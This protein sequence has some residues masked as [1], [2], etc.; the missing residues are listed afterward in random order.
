MQAVLQ[1]LTLPRSQQSPAGSPP[2]SPSPELDDNFY[3]IQPGSRDEVYEEPA[4][5]RP[6]L[7]SGWQEH[8][9]IT[10]SAPSG[11]RS[12]YFNDLQN[13]G[14][15]RPSIEPQQSLQNYAYPVTW[16]Y[17][18]PGTAAHDIYGTEI[19]ATPASF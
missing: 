18:L 6:R 7:D 10:L 1:P 16:P 12:H 17:L 13:I 4:A 2:K 19:L 8:D 3:H 15:L 9:R 11:S 5:K 14:N